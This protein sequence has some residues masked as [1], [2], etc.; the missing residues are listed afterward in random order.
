MHTFLAHPA[1]RQYG[2]NARERRRNIA[3]MIAGY[4]GPPKMNRLERRIAALS[5]RRRKMA[6]RMVDAGADW[7]TAPIKS[8]RWLAAW[9]SDQQCIAADEALL[10]AAR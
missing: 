6:E 9:A 8:A 1:D 7:N 10:A 5:P 2:E 4:G 3:K